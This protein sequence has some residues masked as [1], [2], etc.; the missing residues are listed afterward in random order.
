MRLPGPEKDS[1]GKVVKPGDM[2]IFTAGQSPIY[3]RQILYFFDPV[4]S[5]RA[6]ITVPGLT[7]QYQ[8]GITDSI[9]EPRPAAWYS[10]TPVVVAQTKPEPGSTPDSRG[11]YEYFQ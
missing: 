3:G 7:P 8:S 9:Y 10:A 5:A 11:A 2:L 4:F 1:Q 6:K